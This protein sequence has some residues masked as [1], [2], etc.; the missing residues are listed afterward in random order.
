MMD[1]WILLPILLPLLGGAG[2]LLSRIGER[3]GRK[4]H[5]YTTVILSVSVAAALLCA[6]TGEHSLTLPCLVKDVPVYFRVDALG[7]WFVTVVSLVWLA[8]GFFAFA[9]MEHA[10]R[11]KQY[12]GFYLIL[13]GVLVA[14]D[15][16]GNLVTMYLFYELTTLLSVPL[17]LHNRTREALMAALKYLFYSL[18]GAYGGLFGIFFLHRYCDGLAFRPGGALDAAQAAGHEGILLTA[19]FVMLLG[20]GAKAGMLPLHGWLPT[21]HPAAPSPA[22]AVLSGVIVKAGVLAMIRAVYYVVGPEFIRGTWV[23]RAWMILALLTVF[24]GSMLAYRQQGI[25]KRLAYSTVSQV[26]YITFGLSLLTPS[27]M[28]GALLHVAVHAVVKCGLFLTAGVFVQKCGAARVDELSGTG[29]K[30]PGVMCCY[31][32]F[33]LGLIGIPPFCGFI[34]K[35]YLAQGALQSD[36]GIFSWLGP[37]VL[38]AS[39]LLT[40]GYLL[41]IA[42]KGFFPG[43]EEGGAEMPESRPQPPESRLQPMMLWPLVCLAGIALLT[44]LFPGPLIRYAAEIAAAALR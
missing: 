18:C 12:F 29:R 37:A 24:M 26:S 33:S 42:V 39:A 3:D 30:M 2:L 23:Q 43:R 7:R 4:I 20:F 6:W 32:L 21:A 35:W 40:A 15:F 19:V 28:E 11:E 31:T 16:S 36:T 34:S 44:G 10:G 1:G 17:V 22:S 27:G 13:Y 8:A 9:Y 38:L 5:V 25:K 14:L 41:P